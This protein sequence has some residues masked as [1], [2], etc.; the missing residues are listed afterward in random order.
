MCGVICVVLWCVCV[1]VWCVCVFV[2]CVFVC[3]GARS[4]CEN[5]IV[6]LAP[7]RLTSTLEFADL[8]SNP[9]CGLSVSV[10]TEA[11]PLLPSLRTR[12]T[13]TFPRCQDVSTSSPLPQQHTPPCHIANVNNNAHRYCCCLRNYTRDSL[14]LE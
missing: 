11:P 10:D 2:V 1:C 8:V 6:H 5:Y 7:S 3:V 12:S 14:Q 9:I 4:L 13:F